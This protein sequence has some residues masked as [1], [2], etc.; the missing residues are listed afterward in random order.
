MKA[1]ILLVLVL[2]GTTETKANEY[3]INIISTK[4]TS[5]LNGAY[6]RLEAI[7][8]SNYSTECA[9]SYYKTYILGLG[10]G[11]V[12]LPEYFSI[13]L[14]AGNYELLSE[15]Y[16]YSRDSYSLDQYRLILSELCLAGVSPKYY[17]EH[18]QAVYPNQ[19]GTEIRYCK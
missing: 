17:L 12:N 5:F 10:L 3:A 14:N 15:Y 19:H 4:C 11:E 9:L 7:A 8:A 6:D 1:A 16:N 13:L 2:I 18:F